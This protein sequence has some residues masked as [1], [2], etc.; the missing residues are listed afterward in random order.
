VPIIG[1]NDVEA[2]GTGRGSVARGIIADIFHRNVIGSGVSHKYLLLWGP[3]QRERFT[4]QSYYDRFYLDGGKF[5]LYV[6]HRTNV[7]KN[8]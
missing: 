4:P 6:R 1:L 8:G 3:V 2:Q 5:E 7:V